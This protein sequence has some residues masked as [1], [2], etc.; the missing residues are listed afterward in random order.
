MGDGTHWGVGGDRLG[1][2]QSR[3]KALHP[4]LRKHRES[5]CPMGGIGHRSAR[6]LWRS[7]GAA[8]KWAAAILLAAVTA[9]CS[10]DPLVYQPVTTAAYV[11]PDNRIPE[12]LISEWSLVPE[13][14]VEVRAVWAEQRDANTAPTV[15]FFPGQHGNIDTH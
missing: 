9:A 8:M 14:D 12:E 4:E 15:L 7:G 1:G 5:R 11:L 6:E 2:T 3:C 13:P 10:A